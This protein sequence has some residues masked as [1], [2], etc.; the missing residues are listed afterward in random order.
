[1]YFILLVLHN[2]DLLEEVLA[3]WESAGAGGVTVLPSIGYA[4]IKDKRSLREDFPLIPGLSDVIENEND[5][6]R[7]LLS[8]VK[9]EEVKDRVIAVTREVVGDLNLPDTGILAVMPVRQAF[10]LDRIRE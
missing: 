7:T 10:G 8:I 3:A 9:T 6:N 5:Q 1:M 2:I 4:K